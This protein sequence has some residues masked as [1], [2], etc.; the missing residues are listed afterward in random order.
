MRIS[1]E[2]S[3]NASDPLPTDATDSFGDAHSCGAPRPDIH[4]AR[5]VNSRCRLAKWAVN[6]VYQRSVIVELLSMSFPNNSAMSG[7]AD[8]RSRNEANAGRRLPM[9][10]RDD[11]SFADRCTAPPG[12]VAECRVKGD[13]PDGTAI[14]HRWSSRA[15]K[16]SGKFGSAKY[17]VTTSCGVT[18]LPASIAPQSG[19][20]VNLAPPSSNTA[21]APTRWARQFGSSNSASTQRTRSSE[22]IE[23]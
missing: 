9:H 16:C 21:I 10:S 1:V 5:G 14:S 23:D 6:C 15:I 4:L 8:A 11:R 20:A 13:K 22:R 19:A 12:P 17:A 3:I 2:Q 18:Q 7:S